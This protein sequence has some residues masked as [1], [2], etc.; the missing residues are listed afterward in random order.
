ML[1]VPE[2]RW[3]LPIEW[4]RVVGKWWYSTKGLSGI[5]GCFAALSFAT[6]AMVEFKVFKSSVLEEKKEI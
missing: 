1:A 2:C 4:I 6:V 3:G 5:G